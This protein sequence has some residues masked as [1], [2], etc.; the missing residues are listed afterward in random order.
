VDQPEETVADQR[1]TDQEEEGG[2]EDRP[3]RETGQQH[4]YEQRDPEDGNKNHG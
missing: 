2:G 1:P 3:R 4:R